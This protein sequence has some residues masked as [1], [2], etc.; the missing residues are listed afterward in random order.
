MMATLY[1]HSGAIMIE[2]VDLVWGLSVD[3]NLIQ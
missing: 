1:Q 3:S 2:L